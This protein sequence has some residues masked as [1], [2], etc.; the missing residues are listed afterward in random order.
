MFD[1]MIFSIIIGFVFII[2]RIPFIRLLYLLCKA[3]IDW[4]NRH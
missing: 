2:I 1:T 4:L 3:F